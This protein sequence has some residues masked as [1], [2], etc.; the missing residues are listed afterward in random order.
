MGLSRQVLSSRTLLP[1]HHRGF[2]QKV[3]IELHA[4]ARPVRRGNHAIRISK[5]GAYHASAFRGA[6]HTYSM[7]GAMFGVI[8]AKFRMLTDAAPVCVLCGQIHRFRSRAMR[9][10]RLARVTPPL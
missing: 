7:Y 3:G 2:P 9:A 8:A 10:T 1:F 5:F 6:R 4:Q